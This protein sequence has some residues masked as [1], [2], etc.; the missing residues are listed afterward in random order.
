MH[1]SVRA[2]SNPV[3]W[4]YMPLHLINV[5]L[6]LFCSWCILSWLALHS[7]GGEPWLEHCLWCG[8]MVSPAHGGYLFLLGIPLGE[9]A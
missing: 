3:P 9:I 7:G 2:V 8:G 1:G 5:R 4:I 6:L